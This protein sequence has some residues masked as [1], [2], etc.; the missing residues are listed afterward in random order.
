[1]PAGEFT[2]K[3]KYGEFKAQTKLTVEALSGVH[4]GEF[5]AP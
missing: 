1:V 3:M 4:E 2:V 5:V